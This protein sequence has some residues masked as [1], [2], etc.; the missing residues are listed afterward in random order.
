MLKNILKRLLEAIPT[1]WVVMT[2][3]FLMI[4]IAPGGPFDD[5]RMLQP[6]VEEQL[7]SHYGLDQSLW[8]QY[9]DYLNNI[10]HGNLGPSLKY[11]GVYVQDLIWEKIPVTL[12]LAFY[13]FGI[14]I[15][16]GIGIGLLAATRPNTWVDRAFMAIASM[17][18][19]LPHFVLGPL[20][21]VFF[22][23]QLGWVKTSGWESWVDK[24]LP[25]M[26]LSAYYLAFIARLIRSHML[27]ILNQDYIRTAYAKGLSTWRVFTRHGLRN[28]VQPVVAF[29]A[30]TIAAL[31]SGSFAVE[32]IFHIPGL[33]RFF[34]QS[35]FNRD[36]TL[37]LGVI[38]FYAAGLILLNII[39]DLIM[40][41]LNPVQKK[42]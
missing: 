30:P 40:V 16:V 35:A 19:S 37:L 38:L 29:S 8:V 5:E 39:A 33:G 6:E 31:L 4:H 20:L 10:L 32:T 28:A 1:L 3:T 34:I 7:A 36:Y 42:I 27:D 15:I 25:C 9:T 14:A 21:L 41:W 22:A 17:G 23:L 2:L 18:I 24:I 11:A 26:T 12:E 13:S